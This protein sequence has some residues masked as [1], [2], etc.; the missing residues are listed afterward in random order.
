LSGINVKKS[1]LLRSCVAFV[2]PVAAISLVPS[3]AL[4]QQITTAIQGRVTNESGAPLPNT[5]ITITDTRTGNTQEFTTNAQGL[6]SAQNLTTG[7]PYTISATAGG[8]Q[9]QTVEQIFTSLQG[10]TQLTFSL[11]AAATEAESEAIVVTAAR[12]RA[13]QLEVGPGTAFNTEVMANAPSFNRD[14]RDVI[15]IDPR[16]S[17][18]RDDG[19]SGQD[20]ISCLGGNDRGNSFTVD[21]L[22][23]SD[24][25]GLNDTG[26]S[27]RSSTPVPYDAVRETQV[28]FAPMDTEYGNFTGCAINVVTKS[29][30]N[31]FHGSAFY[32][33]SDDGLRGN[34]VDGDPVGPVEADKRWGVAFGGPIIKDRL[35]FFGAYEKQTSG[36]SQ[37]DGPVGGGFPNEVVG[38]TVA[39]FNAIS[40]VLSSVYGIDTGPLVTN[41]PF[42]NKRL[43]GRVD[44]QITDDH[45]F[46]AT[47]QRLKESTMRSDDFFT[48]SSPQVTGANTFLLSG[49]N[50]KYY[51]AR[52][53]STWSDVVSTEFRYSHADVQD[54]QDPVG[55]GEAQS[56]NPIPRII[57]GIDNPSG[58]PDATI[59]AGPGTSRSANDLKTKVDL[60]K[61]VANFDTGDHRL[62]VGVEM[63]KTDIFNLFVQNAT[64][65]LVFRN[66][67][68][69]QAGLL[70]PGAAF[71]NPTPPPANLCTASNSTFPLNVVNG[72][73]FGAFGNFSRTGDVNDAAAEFKRTIYSIYFQDDWRVSDRLNAVAGVRMDMFDGPGPDVNPNFT[74]RYGFDNTTGFSDVDPV[75]LPRIGLTY[76]LN[77]FSMFRRAK[78]TGGVGIFSGGDPLVWFA[79]AFQNNGFGFAEGTTASTSCPP[80]QISVLTNGQ[81]TG[82]PACF[83]QD[84]I[85][86]AAAGSGDTQ[87]VDPDIKLPTVWRA[88]LGFQSDFE[89]GTSPF[90]TGWR[91]N[92]DYI[93]SYYK[94]PFTIV[95]LS[96]TPNP[97]SGLNGF[98]IDGR[99]IYAAIDPT[100]VNCNAE[101]VDINPTPVWTNVTA[102]CFGTSRDDELMLTNSKGYRSHIASIILSKDFD[103]G[104]FTEGGSSYFNLGYAYTASQDRRNM[105][106]STAGSNYDATAAFDR[107]NPSASRGFYGSKHN[108]TFSGNFR[109]EFLSDLATSLGFSFVARSGRPYSLTFTGGGVFNDSASGNENA[110][111]YIPSGINDPNISPSSN[112][113]AV[114]QLTDFARGLDC[115]KKYLGRSI[116]RNTCEND[117]YF[118]LDLRLAQEIPGPARL[119]G[120]PLGVKDKFTLYAMFD[121]FLNFLNDGWNVQRR[122]EFNGLQDIANISG[123]DSQ[124]RYI[125]SGA[126][127]LNV[128]SDGLTGYQ[129]DEFIN[130]SSS[131]WRIKVGLSY[132]F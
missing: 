101:L 9:G 60:Y 131:L 47:Y 107:Q 31:K 50:S 110:L 16:V 121:N 66:L 79:N 25:Y 125:I 106:R 20:R 38:V 94:N 73:S 105:F 34:S 86:R 119:L 62:K 69:L 14:V 23:Q 40:D 70:S 28:Q 82:L 45:R 49:T 43:F 33:Y 5:Q 81:F 52:L 58:T 89:F 124:G 77:E 29:G 128:G 56:G 68:D 3:V 7:G 78:L 75:F 35:F 1:I 115:A 112:M 74:A 59:L 104:I 27:S 90:A 19:G 12:V 99:P 64:G 93:Y 111:A 18:D 13:T 61:A 132:E 65:T 2:T 91:V 46:E 102:A 10:A 118:D 87:S 117:W 54:I 80:G 44:W 85:N 120:S 51:S 113:A 24:I 76:D 39:Q 36:S 95:D 17:L 11:T 127:Q 108:I 48:G 122:R 32:E 6:F 130:V 57:V 126:D 97:A 22:A 109:E 88:N 98:T 71:P 84:G 100:R 42:T 21:G 114:Q 92:L 72:C 37:D 123:V 53:Y 8:Y 96:Q 4:A 83:Q 55:G 129:R 26:F 30:T 116:K 67:A 41:R 15:R 103:R 63:D